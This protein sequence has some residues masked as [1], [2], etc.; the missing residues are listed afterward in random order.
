M[1]FRFKSYTVEIT[2]PN[3]TAGATSRSQPSDRRQTTKIDSGRP[4]I[5]GPQQ[6]YG[7]RRSGD[8]RIGESPESD[9]RGGSTLRMLIGLSK[10]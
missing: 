6:T 1:L 5:A 7:A 10:A 9:P 8:D 4:S 3:A 2:V